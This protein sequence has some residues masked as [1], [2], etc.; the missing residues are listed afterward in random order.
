MSLSN[1]IAFSVQDAGGNAAKAAAKQAKSGVTA[2][3]E[4]CLIT[5]STWC[6]ARNLVTLK[7]PKALLQG[8]IAT[9]TVAA[10]T[11]KIWLDPNAVDGSWLLDDNS[12]LRRLSYNVFLVI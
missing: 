11:A 1:L 7:F 6:T 10:K 2:A 4:F 12:R 9:C 8:S 3:H 5:S